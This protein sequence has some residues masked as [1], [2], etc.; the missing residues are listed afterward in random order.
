MVIGKKTIQHRCDL[1][2]P[3]WILHG[4]LTFN[5]NMNVQIKTTYFK[6]FFLVFHMQFRC[7]HR[8]TS[9]ERHRTNAQPHNLS[10]MFNFVTLFNTQSKLYKPFHDNQFSPIHIT[11]FVGE[12][13]QSF[14]I[15]SNNLTV[16]QSKHIE[17]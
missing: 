10:F 2:V 5:K 12:F 14:E 11:C 13:R 4:K 15:I 17:S 9:F 6:V 1:Y 3:A 7:N 8:K 16:V